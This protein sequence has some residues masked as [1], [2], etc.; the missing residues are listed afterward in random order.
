MALEAVTPKGNQLR[1]VDYKYN[2][3]EAL[4]FVATKDSGSSSIG[5]P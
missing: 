5:E 2:S 3:H 4:S 1:A